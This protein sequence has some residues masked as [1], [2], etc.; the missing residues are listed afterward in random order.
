MVYSVG[1]SKR[2]AF[3]KAKELCHRS[4]PTSIFYFEILKSTGDDDDWQSARDII[5]EFYEFCRDNAKHFAII[6]DASKLVYVDAMNG[7]RW[8][9]LFVKHKET[10]RQLLACTCL[11]TTNEYA[12]QGIDYFLTL[13]DP[14]KPF[15]V[16]SNLKV[17]REFV[18]RTTSASV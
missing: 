15:R 8:V 18:E 3:V 11:V 10:T 2:S 4:S 1:W 14:I 7:I 13:Y 6:M 9:A 17:A 5:E 12:K 16:V